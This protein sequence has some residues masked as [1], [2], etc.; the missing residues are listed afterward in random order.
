ME[1][2][3]Q[4]SVTQLHAS[5]SPA[6]IS[7]DIQSITDPSTALQ[8]F[9]S[10]EHET[11]KPSGDANNVPESLDVHQLQAQVTGIVETEGRALVVAALTDPEY[12]DVHQLE[13]QAIHMIETEGRTLLVSYAS[14]IPIVGRFISTRISGTAVATTADGKQTEVNVDIAD[15]E[16]L[17]SETSPLLGEALRAGKDPKGYAEKRIK[18]LVVTLTG[19]I[20]SRVPDIEAYGDNNSDNQSLLLQLF[21]EVFVLS[22]YAGPLF[23][24]HIQEHSLAV[25]PTVSLGHLST[26][27]LAAST[28]GTMAASITGHSIIQ[29]F[30]SALDGLLASA[31]SD[32]H[33]ATVWC[34]RTALIT[35]IVL[36]PIVQLWFQAESLLLQIGQDPEVA[37][38]ASQFLRFTA[39]GL[40][41]YAFNEIAKRYLI[42][43]DLSSVH[44]RILTMTAP[45]NMLL[46]YL[47]VDGPE[48]FRLGFVGAPVSTAISHNLI[49]ILLFFYI[50]KRVVTKREELFARSSP[51]PP[52]FHG[53]YDL[54]VAGI[55]GVARSASQ[56]WSKD[57]GGLAA[58]MLGPI[59]LATQAILLTTATTLHQAPR[60]LSSSSSNRVKKL[61]G[62]GDVVRA[63]IATLVSFVATVFGV[64]TL[65][66]VLL[67]S[68]D[69]WGELFNNDPAVLQNVASVLPF[70]ALF[71]AVHG[72]GAWVDGML[73]ALGKTAIYPALN[74]SSDYFVGIPLGLYLAFGRHWGLSGLWAGLIASLTYSL[75][76][77]AIV[78]LT[79]SWSSRD[80]NTREAEEDEPDCAEV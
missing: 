69:S 50:L 61:L 29:G 49:S 64:L 2:E 58:S 54:L 37:S 34:L 70:I 67:A 44:T 63:R 60:A 4:I 75:V 16:G 25:A 6:N 35:A 1:I 72:L 51:P 55:S 21:I 45:L 14:R 12:I 40:P 74:A 48:S 39:I 78:L 65:S 18:A 30:I 11:I 66:N 9:L 68:A 76:V 19:P 36:M 43:Q 47:L 13:S 26:T 62:R 3:Q 17:V 32:H 10:D 28:I 24:S 42:S 8:A 38:L 5:V 80:K 41:S 79:S 71:Q 23:F 7:N 33:L 15:V 20:M 59:A 73:G 56:L 57:L 53:M 27:T 22:K 52:F 77:A 46:N 31:G